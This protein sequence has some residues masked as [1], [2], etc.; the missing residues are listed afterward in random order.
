MIKFWSYKRELNRYKGKLNS[1]IN[2]S[3]KSGNIFFGEQ[4]S[5]FEKKFIK[6]NK[7]KY[8]IAVGSGT[9]AL[10]IALTALG[11]KKGDQVITASNTAIPTIT[12]IIN[13]GATPKLVDVG[14]DF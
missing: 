9:D 6:K 12:A 1:Q 11:I 4:L 8:G 3:L 13:S 2:K 5:S 14:D 10:L 7:S